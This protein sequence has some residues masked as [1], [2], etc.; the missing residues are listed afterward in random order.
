MSHLFRLIPA[1]YPYLTD[2]SIVNQVLLS[3]IYAFSDGCLLLVLVVVSFKP[4]GGLPALLVMAFVLV[5]NIGM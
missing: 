5:P 1:F 4:I 2:L 3:V